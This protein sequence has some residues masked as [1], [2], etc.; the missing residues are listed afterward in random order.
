M[1]KLNEADTRAYLKQLEIA[2]MIRRD[3]AKNQ[4]ANLGLG[5]VGGMSDIVN[6][7]DEIVGR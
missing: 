6:Q 1:V 7:A 5:N 4:L 3:E 2:G